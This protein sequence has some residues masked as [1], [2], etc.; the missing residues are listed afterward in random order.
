MPAGI[1]V[2]SKESIDHDAAVL[3]PCRTWMLAT[4]LSEVTEAIQNQDLGALRCL[5]GVAPVT[6]TSGGSC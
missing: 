5:C 2:H 6:L 3:A 1:L 4:F